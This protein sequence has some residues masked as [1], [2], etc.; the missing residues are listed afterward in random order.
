MKKMA[1]IFVSL[2][3]L[4]PRIFAEDCGKPFSAKVIRL[5]DDDQTYF[6]AF[7]DINDKNGKPVEIRGNQAILTTAFINS[8]IVDVSYYD[9]WGCRQSISIKK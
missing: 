7:L 5:E 9:S 4:S 2:L 6:R 1:L 8:L 3:C